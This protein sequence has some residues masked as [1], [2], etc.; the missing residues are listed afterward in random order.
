[1]RCERSPTLDTPLVFPAVRGGHIDSEKFRSRE[2]APAL[3]AAGIPHRRVYDARHTFAT[4]AIAGGMQ[5]FYLARI[6]GRS[7]AQLDA[8]YGHLSPTRRTTSAACSAHSTNPPRTF[9]D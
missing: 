3:R 6:M 5:L 7:V 2:W 9:V 8:T 4:W 1:M